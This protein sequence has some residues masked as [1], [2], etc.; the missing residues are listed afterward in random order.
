MSA[1]LSLEPEEDLPEIEVRMIADGDFGLPRAF[2]R[3]A[4]VWSEIEFTEYLN[5]MTRK[6]AIHPLEAPDV[7]FD[8]QLPHRGA[9]MR[10]DIMQIAHAFMLRRCLGKGDERF[11][12]VLDADPWLA[13]AFVSAFAG[14]V[15]QGQADVSVVRFD[16]NK[17]NNQRN[18][19]VGDGRA[20]LASATGLEPAALNALT[21]RQRIDET[22]AAIEKMRRGHIPGTPFSWPFHT[23]SEPN[24]QIR[25][26][27][28]K[29]AMAPDR[30]ARLMRL[31][32]LRSVDA[33]FHKVRSNV[34]FASRPAHTPSNNNRA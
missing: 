32:T 15:K 12:F 28:D 22:D 3:Q 34:R 25:P 5:K 21:A 30:R 2:R 9:P 31:S 11:V 16:K 13:L 27:T 29:V 24:R 1:H 20:S 8:L 26:L 4:R 23:K 33:Y 19:L 7:D 17:S 10:Q 18:M 6:V 14:W